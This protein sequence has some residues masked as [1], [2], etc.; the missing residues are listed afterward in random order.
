MAHC[1][2]IWHFSSYVQTH[3]DTPVELENRGPGLAF[4][5]IFYY[6]PIVLQCGSSSHV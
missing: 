5:A 2:T 3:D 1:L 4:A 6:K